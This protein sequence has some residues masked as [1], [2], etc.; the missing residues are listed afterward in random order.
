MTRRTRRE[1]PATAEVRPKRAAWSG[2][3]EEGKEELRIEEGWTRKVSV[4]IMSWVP[5]PHPQSLAIILFRN[6]AVQWY[7]NAE[8]RADQ[9]P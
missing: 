4:G 1:T 7:Y 3:G 5:V 9:Q 6:S 2:L 8:D